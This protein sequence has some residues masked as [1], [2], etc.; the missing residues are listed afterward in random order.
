MN[1]VC[2]A[3]RVNAIEIRD[4]ESRYRDLVTPRREIKM[5]WEPQ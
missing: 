1:I 4:L 5:S 2:V 3:Y